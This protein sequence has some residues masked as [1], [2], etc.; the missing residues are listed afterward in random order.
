MAKQTKQRKTSGA[1]KGILLSLNLLLVLAT[2]ISYIAPYI[3][4]E[5]FWIPAILGLAFP[6]LILLNVAFMLTW[7]IAGKW[8]LIF[9]L[10]TLLLGIPQMTL[11]IQFNEK[12]TEGIA[13]SGIKILSFNTHNL[14]QSPLPTSENPSKEAIFDYLDMEEAQ[15][16]CLQEFTTTGEQHLSEVRDLGK[17]LELPYHYLSNYYRGTLKKTNA[18]ITFSRWPVVN[19]GT[20]RDNRNKAFAVYTDIP[21]READTVRIYN[22]HLE[23]VNF[24]HKDYD[25]VRDITTPGHVEQDITQGSFSIL[26]KLKEAYQKRVGQVDQLTG[27]MA[28][29]P[30]P[31]ILCG[32]FNVTPT[33]YSYH[34]IS[35]GLKDTFRECGR[36]FASTFRSTLP[37]SLRIDYILSDPS[38][39][40][41]RH[42][43]GKFSISDHFPVSA[44]ILFPDGADSV[45]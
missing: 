17:R 27:H 9:S 36:G 40:C 10:V 16:V 18:L 35:K 32:D 12:Y 26:K 20:L 33:S 45:K 4:P 22:I 23:S 21:L 2:L 31:L 34:K 11:Y 38:F 8:Q 42:S 13:Q 39:S 1:L 30:Y 37:I 3:N 19:T 7:M 24:Q 28:Q 14:T 6:Y 15:I 43:T 41:C 29:C 5:V 44:F 25:F